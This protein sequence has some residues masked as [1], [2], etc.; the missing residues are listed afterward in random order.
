MSILRYTLVE[1]GRSDA[2]LAHVINW[3]LGH[4]PQR[5]FSEFIPQVADLGLL[6]NPPKDLTARMQ[7]ACRQFP[8]DLLFVH[9]DAERESVEKRHR[10]IR[11]AARMTALPPHEAG[12]DLDP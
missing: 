2:C 5:R 1:D 11:D 12:G 8:C 6:R 4:D 9:R 10:E 7:A 3:V